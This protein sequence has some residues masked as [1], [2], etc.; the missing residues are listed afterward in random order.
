MDLIKSSLLSPVLQAFANPAFMDLKIE[1]A[2]KLLRIFGAN[3]KK[4]RSP[5]KLLRRGFK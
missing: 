1:E 4:D 5:Y 3:F 2:K